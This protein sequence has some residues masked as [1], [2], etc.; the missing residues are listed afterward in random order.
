MMQMELIYTQG[1]VAKER[2]EDS[3]R[4]RRIRPYRSQ[5]PPGLSVV[6]RAAGDAPQ[7]FSELSIYLVIPPATLPHFPPPEISHYKERHIR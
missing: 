4:D 6:V 2:M 7:T 3:E 5:H 1:T